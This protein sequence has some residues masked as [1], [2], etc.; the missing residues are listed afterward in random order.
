YLVPEEHYFMETVELKGLKYDP[1]LK[2]RRSGFFIVLSS[3]LTF[4]IKDVFEASSMSSHYDGCHIVGYNIN[5][6][7]MATFRLVFRMSKAQQ[8]SDSFVQDLLRTGLR[9]ALHEEPIEV[10]QFGEI[11]TIVLLRC[12]NNTFT[13]DNG[14]C[15]TK[16]NPE[17]DFIAD[18][19]D[20]SDEARCCGTRPAMGSRIVGGEN[21]QQ[22]ELPWQVSLRLHG[23]H[24]CGASILN[25]QWLVSAAHCFQNNPGEWMALVG[26]RLISGAESVSKLIKIKSVIVNPDY[27][28]TT[29]DYD[30]SLLELETPLTFSSY[31][32]PVCLP[33]SSHVFAPGQSCVV[34]GWGA[35]N[36]FSV[37]LPSALQKAVVKVI[38]TKE[39][40]NT[41]VYRGAITQNMM[42]AGFLQGR[43]DSCQLQ[44][45]SGGPLVCEGAPGRFFLA[46]VV[47][48]GMGCAQLNKPGVYTR[49]TALS[50]WI[51]S[52]CG[53]RPILGSHRIVGGVTAR[54]GEWPWIG[55]LQYR[56][57]HRCGATLIDRKWLLTAAHCFKDPSP[58]NWAVSLGSV[59][60]TGVGALIIP[61]HR[62]IIHP[63]FNGTNM[64]QDVAL[65]ELALP[66]PMSN[67]I[68]RVCL[69]SPVHHFLKNAECYIAGWGS[70]KEGSLT[71]L[72]QNAAVKI[73]DQADCQRPYR[74]ALTPNMMCAGYMEGGR[75]TCLGDS[76]G[77]LTCRQYS[78]QWFIAGVTSWGHGCGRIGFPGVYT[79]VTSVRTWISTYLSF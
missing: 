37:V 55:S 16:I 49:I 41:S 1:V 12:P 54:R 66:A 4:K 68:Q 27:N 38:N 50:N 46:G 59:L 5:G 22:G 61:I 13:C 77:P 10:P 60:R 36:E 32:Q 72:L 24:T 51:V 14:E 53:V 74:D 28:P 9:A 18:C 69:P 43:V 34:S 45:D 63:A 2:D 79:R 58:I 23:H 70:M 21:A 15:V 62:V 47:S 48:W 30:V 19:A 64:D 6:D 67:T 33:S 73:I 44:G 31:I 8:F 71:N 52:H 42:C 75:D 78:G 40:N 39:C 11:N 26:A 56:S 65:L 76:G 3:V 17:C 25:K 20:G 57:L 35:L 29:N 7:V